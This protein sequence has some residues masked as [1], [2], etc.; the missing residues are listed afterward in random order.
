M[1]HSYARDELSRAIYEVR[2]LP[3]RDKSA[4]IDLLQKAHTIFPESTQIAAE[5]GNLLYTTG[6]GV[7][8]RNYFDYACS[9]KLVADLCKQDDQTK[10][11]PY[12]WQ[13]SRY[14][15]QVLSP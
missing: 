3:L 6:R 7:E 8:A 2:A 14:I 4:T 12:Q 10:E 13:F 1:E 11:I 9:Q 15:R 5:L